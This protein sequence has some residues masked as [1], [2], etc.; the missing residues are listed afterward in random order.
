MQNVVRKYVDIGVV[1]MKFQ[2]IRHKTAVSKL[3]K[4]YESE[5]DAETEIKDAIIE[6]DL[7]NLKVNSGKFRR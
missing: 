2:K 3:Q 1:I 4:D 6:I 7:G 5:S